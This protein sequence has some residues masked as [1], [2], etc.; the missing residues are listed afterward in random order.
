[1]SDYRDVL[2]NLE[3]QVEQTEKEFDEVKGSINGDRKEKA[4]K[5]IDEIESQIEFL[6]DQMSEME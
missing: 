2:D 5:L 1:M 3:T 6:E 4:E